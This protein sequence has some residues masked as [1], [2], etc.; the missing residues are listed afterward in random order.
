[1]NVFFPRTAYRLVWVVL[2]TGYLLGCKRSSTNDPQ[3]A[4]QYLVSSTL[5]G[6]FTKEQLIARPSPIGPL[7]ASL[8]QQGIRVRRLVY[9]TKNWDGSDVSASGLLITPTTP[10]AVPM[11]SAQ[12]G[13][14][15]SDAEAPSYYGASSEAYQFGSLFAAIGYIIVCPDYLGFGES[16]DVA[17][18]YEHRATY[19]SATLDMLRAAREFIRSDASVNWDNRLYL[20]GYSAGGTATMALYQKLQNEAPTEF[21]LRAVSCGAGAYDKTEF[22]RTVVGQPSSGNPR[23]NQAFVWTLL[24]YN[25]I[26]GLNRPLS[27]YFKEPY[28]TEVQKN[29]QLANITVSMDQTFTDAFKRG[30]LDG[31]DTAFLNALA[32]NNVYDWKPATLLHLYHGDADVQVFYLN[33]QS[34]YTAMQK[35]GVGQTV[36]LNTVPG[37]THASTIQNWLLGTFNL[38]QST[39]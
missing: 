12:H 2:L 5:V 3:P 39:P 11:I 24:A 9:K 27:Y 28:L 25:Q 17:H 7:Y 15:Y 21:N 33:A 34:A 22:S 4:N 26:Y 37:G 29:R 18:P 13:T 8:I 16:K 38:I 23:A 31:T 6:E 30:V 20:S 10:N 19:A 1:M 36:R 14:I 35:R 32:D